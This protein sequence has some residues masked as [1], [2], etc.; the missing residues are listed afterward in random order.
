MDIRQCVVHHTTENRIPYDKKPY[1][2]RFYAVHH[3][4]NCRMVFW[5]PYGKIVWPYDKGGSMYVRSYDQPYTILLERRAVYHIR[6]VYR[7]YD[8]RIRIRHR[9]VWYTVRSRHT[10]AHTYI[11]SNMHYIQRGKKRNCRT[12]RRHVG[13][14]PSK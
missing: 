11:N 8:W 12:S 7:P 2:I 14:T 4:T 3:T 6:L 13:A 5:G 1:T 10:H 9:I